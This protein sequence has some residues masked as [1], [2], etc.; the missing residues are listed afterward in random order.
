MGLVLALDFSCVTLLLVVAL[1]KGFERALPLAAFLML[2]FPYESQ[3]KIPGLFDLTTQ[4][5]IIMEL[6]ILYILIE[7]KRSAA[8]GDQKL[9]LCGLILLLVGWMLFSSANSVVPDVSFK[10]TLSQVFDFALPY[11]LFARSV[12]KCE[13]VEKILFAFFSVVFVLSIFGAFEAYTGWSVLAQF[14]VAPHRFGGMPGMITDRGIRVQA[15]FGTPIMFGTALAMSIPMGLYLLTQSK[16]VLRKL[17]LWSAIFLMFLNIFK[18]GS[19][20]PWIALI[21]SLTILLF[22]GRG[23]TRRQLA[24]IAMLSVSVLIARPGVWQTLV[25]LYE[26]TNNPDTNQGASYEWRYALYR[27]TE[28]ELSKDLG[29]A[30]WGFG[31]ESF[32]YL[33]L[34]GEFQGAVWKFE[35]CD[36]EVV[37]LL[38]DTG[39]I[40]FLIVFLIVAKAAQSS[41]RNALRMPAPA[42]SLCLLLFVNIVAFAF[43]MTNVEIFWGQQCYMFWIL[44]ALTMTYPGL[45]YSTSKRDVREVLP[46]QPASALAL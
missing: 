23:A 44:M 24:F 7:R 30:I 33:G 14:P 13:T 21:L 12:S 37:E 2:L 9:P 39:C 22:L 43:M 11:Y 28:R 38:M 5:I 18:T 8:E 29:R 27:I 16:T 31:P 45:V 20:G 25:N 26:E 46:Q 42:N 17:F 36:S 1:M 41:L 34:E 3:I 4:R 40:G 6:V 35:T 10:A 19:R 15:T 32:Y